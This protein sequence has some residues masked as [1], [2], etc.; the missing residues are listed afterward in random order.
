MP[1]LAPANHMIFWLC[2]TSWLTFVLYDLMCLY[3]VIKFFV[4][5]SVQSSIWTRGFIFRALIRVMSLFKIKKGLKMSITS[6]K[7]PFSGCPRSRWSLPYCTLRSCAVCSLTLPAT[8]RK[9]RGQLVFN[10]QYKLTVKPPFSQH[11]V[12]AFFRIE[13]LVAVYTALV[14]HR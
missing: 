4:S 12:T 14:L 3:M 7:D 11:A 8:C 1:H 5:V 13:Q 10:S 9:Y 6:W 2:I